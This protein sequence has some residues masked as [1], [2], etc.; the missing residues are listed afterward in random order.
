M[1]VHLPGIGP[2]R[3]AGDEIELPQHIAH[4]AISLSIGAQL[5][6]LCHHFAESGFDVVDRALRVVLALRIEAALTADELLAVETG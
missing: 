5:I 2:G 1:S 3:K 6:E 4:N